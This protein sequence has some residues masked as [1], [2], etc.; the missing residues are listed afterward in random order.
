[1]TPT[2]TAQ[3]AAGHRVPLVVWGWD[4]IDCQGSFGANDCC[5]WCGGTNR[6]PLYARQA[7]VARFEA[8]S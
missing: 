6:I 8:A 4:C 2:R 1:M 7:D 5:D 3:D